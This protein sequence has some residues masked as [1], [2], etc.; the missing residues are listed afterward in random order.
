MVTDALRRSRQVL[1]YGLLL[2]AALYCVAALSLMFKS[3][4]D[5][6][7]DFAGKSAAFGYLFASPVLVFSLFAAVALAGGLNGAVSS[8]RVV[9]L[10]ALVVGGMALALAVLTF[11]AGVTATERP[12]VPFGGV[13][14]AGRYVG[15]V[16]GLAQLLLLA[17]VTWFAFTVFR[18]TPPLA[19]SSP[20]E[21]QTITGLEYGKSRWGRDPGYPAD[22]GWDPSGQGQQ[23]TP[24][25]GSSAAGW[26]AQYQGQPAAVWGTDAAEYP[27]PDA[28][29][30]ASGATAWDDPTRQ[31]SDQDPTAGDEDAP[32]ERKWWQTPQR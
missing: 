24:P 9:A 29:T 21:P 14:G 15:T 2:V 17:L 27:G 12:Y 22:S 8:A 13:L 4:S 7:L 1:A 26:G 28:H 31:G 30:T 3:R 20:S 25:G 23:F 10:F 16:L 32:P 19:P 6:R 5:V 18:S 11:L